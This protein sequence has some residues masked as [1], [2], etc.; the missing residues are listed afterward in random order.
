[1]SQTVQPQPV[2]PVAA[3][4]P[5]KK[6][7]AR[8]ASVPK[9]AYIILQL[10]GDDGQPM[11]FDKKRVRILAVER[12]PEKV[13]EAVES[14]EHNNAFYLRVVIPAGSR[15]GVANRPKDTPPTAA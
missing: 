11:P 13:L 8:S 3:E 7:R 12:N 10:M 15:A 14:G 4:Q 6:R 1:M 2:R 9:P 5:A